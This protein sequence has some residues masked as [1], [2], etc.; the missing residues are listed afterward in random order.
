MFIIGGLGM[1]KIYQARHP[2]ILPNAYI[3]YAF[4]AL[5]IMVTVLGVV[6]ISISVWIAYSVILILL[7][8]GLGAQI[9]FLGRWSLDL[10]NL[11]NKIDRSI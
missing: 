6:Y 2:D 10:G 9:Y 1:L 11:F 5:I 4:F 7:T 8:A 3:A